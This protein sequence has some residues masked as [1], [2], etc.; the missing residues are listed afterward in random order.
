M[1]K[2]HQNDHR[3]ATCERSEVAR[4]SRHRRMHESER[5]SNALGV[6]A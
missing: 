4:H 2:L 6:P 3:P 1:M 5:C